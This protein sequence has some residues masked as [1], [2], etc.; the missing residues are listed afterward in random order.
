MEQLIVFSALFVLF[1][2]FGILIDRKVNRL[3]KTLEETERTVRELEVTVDEM[4]NVMIN[5]GLASDKGDIWMARARSKKP[6]HP[7][8][9]VDT[10]QE[11]TI[12]AFE[13]SNGKIKAL[14]NSLNF[15]IVEEQQKFKV[16]KLNKKEK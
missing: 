1:L 8:T 5:T 6:L 2:I 16:I 15:N 4:R 9:F 3:T 10:L 13:D 7:K 14:A 12:N 11:S